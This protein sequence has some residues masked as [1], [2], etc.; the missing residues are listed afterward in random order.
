[1]IIVKI[2]LRLSWSSS[3]QG[4][5][6]SFSDRSFVRLVLLTVCRPVPMLSVVTTGFQ[7]IAPVP[8]KAVPSVY[9]SFFCLLVSSVSNFRPDTRGAVVVTFFLGSLVQ[10]CFGEG[11]TLQTNITGVCSQ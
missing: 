2:Y 9:V 4:G 3:G 7:S 11:G 6:S 5:V 10:S 1:M 8:S